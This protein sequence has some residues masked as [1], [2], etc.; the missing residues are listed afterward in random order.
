[1]NHQF[2]SNKVKNI[3]PVCFLVF[4][5][6]SITVFQSLHCQV[7]IGTTTPNSKAILDIQST[8]KGVL[9]PRLSTVQMNAISGTP[10]GLTIYNTDSG[11]LCVFN[12]SSWMSLC[13]INTAITLSISGDTIKTNTG[14]SI[15]L[16][17][18]DSSTYWKINGNL[19]NNTSHFI[20]TLDS[21]SLRIKINRKNSGF[22]S[23]AN[24]SNTFLGYLAADS[25]TGSK[26]TVLGHLSSNKLKNGND[27]TSIGYGAAI[28]NSTG[29]ENIAIGVNSMQS[30]VAGNGAIAI[31]NA[32]LRYCNS[33][34][35]AFTNNNIAIG[36]EAL[37][38]SLVP[39]SNTGNNNLAIGNQTLLSNTTGYSNIAIGKDALSQNTTGY[40]NTAVGELGLSLNTTGAYNTS[41]G[42]R[43]LYGNRADYNSAFGAYSLTNTTTGINNAGLGSQSLQ[44]NTSGN[45]NVAMGY[46]SIF[47]NLSGSRNIAAGT[48]ALYLNLIG[49]DNTS[50]G[51]QSLYSNLA[52]GNTAIG[53]RAML[54]NVTGGYNTFV[55]FNAGYS[56]VRSAGGVAFGTNAMYYGN[57]VNTLFLNTNTAIG[58][59]A[60]RGSTTAANNIGLANSAMGFSSL[61]LNTSGDSGT[62]L[63]HY[64][65][66]NNS[67]GDNNTAVG[68]FSMLNNTTGK[69]NVA[70]GS[71]SL[72]RNTT[73]NYN[74]VIGFNSNTS[75]NNL[76][77][78]SAIGNFA[79]V[80]TS[81]TMVFGRKD[82]V[83]K[84]AFGRTKATSGVFQ[85]GSTSSDGNGAFL[86]SGGT[87]TNASDINLKEDIQKIDGKLILDNVMKLHI[88]KWK[89]KNTNEYHIGPMAQEFHTLFSTGINS[90]T[91]STVDPAGVALK[92]IQEQQKMIEEL[93]TLILEQQ[94][95]IEL[96]KKK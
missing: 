95:E 26:N 63:G 7:G 47:N 51:H 9:F 70:I 49:N 77:H 58:Y 37:R 89:Y 40:Y 18:L 50:F 2:L 20:G 71:N 29:S 28:N 8:N 69:G 32:A 88:T 80:D 61:K 44:N 48:Q 31:G 60:I 87:W 3:F 6:F 81:N 30:S 94:K 13:R 62:A 91:I 27:N 41:M 59:E 5:F 68:N 82:S 96:L 45:N 90:T 25:C 33:S 78:A 93:K 66:S 64:A 53:S 73:G 92:A 15:Q 21:Q 14:S 75:V 12:G 4:L 42:F 1:M 36:K 24:G 74:L 65:L 79:I 11:C 34:S 22:I 19:G 35:T 85:V 67:S 57:T 46:L 84:W 23:N 56:F 83:N 43:A 76:K 86:T 39:A 38:G 10:T 54:N 72:M 16:P 52:D 17:I 55:G